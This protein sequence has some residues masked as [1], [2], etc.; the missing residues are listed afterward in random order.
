MSVWTGP[1]T[2]FT[3]D[4]MEYAEWDWVQTG[5]GVILHHVAEWLADPAGVWE[6]WDASAR[7]SCGR[8]SIVHIPGLFSRMGADRCRACCR[9]LGIEP[10]VGSPKNDKGAVREWVEA[11]VA[12][13]DFNPVKLTLNA[14]GA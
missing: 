13:M 5:T 1:H 3:R 10:G 9:V 11:R 12:S 8:T 2:E 4:A 7:T 14:P 6:D